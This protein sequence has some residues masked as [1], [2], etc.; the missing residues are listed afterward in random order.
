MKLFKRTL[1]MGVQSMFV[2]TCS[3]SRKQSSDGLGADQRGFG[4]MSKVSK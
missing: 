1:C 3:L 4:E 2:L